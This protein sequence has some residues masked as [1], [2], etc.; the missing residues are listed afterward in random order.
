MKLPDDIFK[1]ELLQYLSIYD[2]VTLDNACI[3]H[4]YRS[5]LLDKISGVIFTGDKGEYLK[6]SLFKWLGMRRIYWINMLIIFSE[7]YIERTSIENEYVDRFRYTQYIDTRGSITDDIAKFIISHGP[8]LISFNFSSWM[9]NHPQITDHTLQSIAAHCTGLQ[10]LSLSYCSSITDTGL[11]TISESCSYLQSLTITYNVL[12]TDASIISIS[13]H[14]T[15]LQSLNLGGCDQITDAC[16]ISI[17]IHCTGLQSLCL[18]ICRQITD[19]SIISISTHCT[20]LQYLCCLYCDGISKM[21]RRSY[22]SVSE[23]RASLSSIYPR[24]LH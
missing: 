10:S 9:D 2:I 13:T 14:C 3:N 4:K 5:Q 1:Q 22:K 17:S 24:T 20:G 12:F 23:L 19:A 6:A 15:G 18:A 7:Y 21:L 16:I 8:C 11:I